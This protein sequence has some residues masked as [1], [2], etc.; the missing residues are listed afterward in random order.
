MKNDQA[1]TVRYLIYA[2]VSERGSSW[3]ADESSI[4]AQIDACR[5]FVA[6]RGG[7]VAAEISDEFLSGGTIDRAGMQRILADLELPEIPWDVLIV[8][9]LSRLTRSNRDGQHIQDALAKRGRGLVSVFEA[10]DYS[11]P[12]GRLFFAQSVAMNQYFREK[13]SADTRASMARM[14]RNGKWATSVPL[15]YRRNAEKRLVIESDGAAT[16]HRIFDLYDSGVSVDKIGETFNMRNQRITYLLRNRTYLGEARFAGETYEG[17]HPAIVDH[18]LFDRVQ[19]RL[20]GRRTKT[21]RARPNAQTRR[22]LLQG[23]LFSASGAA[24]TPWSTKP[25]RT[26]Y[27]YYL[28][29]DKTDTPRRIPADD[30]EN[31]VINTLLD[32]SESLDHLT[33]EIAATAAERDRHTAAAKAALDDAGSELAQLTTESR[34]IDELFLSGVVTAAN[35]GHWNRRHGDIHARIRAI[36]SRLPTMREAALPIDPAKIA[37]RVQA[38]IREMKTQLRAAAGNRERLR[39]IIVHVV[40]RATLTPAG[41]IILDVSPSLTNGVGWHPLFDLVL[42]CE[43]R[44]AA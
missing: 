30:A 40:T 38:E 3:S 32:W 22:Y 31:T 26:H 19:Q 6:S 11:T 20:P 18:L 17:H 41:A 24:M 36:E 8:R 13:I 39:A 14:T 4:A 35:Q 42:R 7:E 1:A 43:V 37:V 5:Y 9:D 21:R 10:I 16:V 12:M 27:Y 28:S 33:A 2:R 15:G 44:I 29:T 25:R 34:R 23:L